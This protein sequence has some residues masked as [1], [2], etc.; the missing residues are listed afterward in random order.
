MSPSPFV[1]SFADVANPFSSSAVGSVWDPVLAD[2]PAVQ[3]DVTARLL[4]VIEQRAQGHPHRCQILFGEPGFGKT[5]LLRRIR[6]AVEGRMPFCWVRM[7]TSPLLLWRHIRYHLADDLARRQ[8]ELFARL[9]AERQAEGGEAADRDLA[10]VLEHLAAGRHVRDARAW[11]AGRVLPEVVLQEL[12]VAPSDADDETLEDES[13]RV[14]LSLLAYLKPTPVVLCLDQM[15]AMQA[16]PGDKQGLFAIG[17]LLSTFHDE[18]PNAVTIGCAQTGLVNELDQTLSK[19]EQDRFETV[20]LRPVERESERRELVLRRLETCADLPRFRPEGADDTWPVDLTRLASQNQREALSVRSLFYQCEQM[21]REAQHLPD[22]HITV[23]DRIAEH[24]QRCLAEAARELDGDRSTGILSDGLPRL[25][26]LRGVGVERKDLPRGLDHVLQGGGGGGGRQRRS[27]ILGN[28]SP[29][30]LLNKLKR[31]ALSA[32]DPSEFVIVRD[33]FHPLSV[34]ALKT[35]EALRDLKARGAKVVTPSRE[36]LLALDAAR[37]LLADAESGELSYRGMRIALKDVEAWV[38]QSVPASLGT[39]LDQIVAGSGARTGLLEQLLALLEREKVVTVDQAAVAA[40]STAEEV[41]RCARHH[42]QAVGLLA[43]A[44]PVLF[45]R[46]SAAAG[47]GGANGRG[48]A[49][50]SSGGGGTPDR[51]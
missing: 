48:T 36:A 31:L 30:S 25:W 7:H 9:L 41:L 50:S 49:F 32:A 18:A 14:T 19:A 11:L 38:R 33:A 40:A 23:Q 26:H 15:E 42:S 2:V 6:L 12:G 39:L 5:H 1:T 46:V 22:E 37:R 13:R 20:T 16:H 44:Q 47:S 21:F 27:V 45:K 43:G 3:A 4:R 51:A 29:I 28:G 17:K 8:Q 35:Q 24:Y 34:S 10:I